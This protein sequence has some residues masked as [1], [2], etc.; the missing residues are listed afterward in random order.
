MCY[1]YAS[2]FHARGGY[3]NRL[4]AKFEDN[5][6]DYPRVLRAMRDHSYA[7]YVGV[8]YVWTEWERCNEVDNISETIL[9][10]DHLLAVEL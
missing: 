1:L 5:V 8:E 3:K 10:R 9:M 2:H 4:Q 6:V 7:G